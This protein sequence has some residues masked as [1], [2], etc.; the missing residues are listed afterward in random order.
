MFKLWPVKLYT[1]LHKKIIEN[2]NSNFQE[3]NLNFVLVYWDLKI[4]QALTGKINVK[5]L[6][7]VATTINV[8][9]LS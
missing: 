9:L 8:E 4:L 3:Q 5:R 1:L 6:P 2:I 7:I